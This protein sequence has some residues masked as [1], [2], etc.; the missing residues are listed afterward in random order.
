[1]SAKKPNHVEAAVLKVPC[2]DCRARRGFW[3]TTRAGHLAGL[4]A[5]RLQAAKAA[6]ASPAAGAV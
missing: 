6:G 4:H 5:A 2:S 3:C 1:M